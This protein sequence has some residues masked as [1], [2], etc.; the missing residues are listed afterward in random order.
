MKA[1]KT[2]GAL[3]LMSLIWGF[4]FTAVPA[5]YTHNIPMS[6]AAGTTIVQETI[7]IGQ[8]VPL[9][10]GEEGIIVAFKEGGRFLANVAGRGIL[11]LPF[12]AIA[13][14]FLHQRNKKLVSKMD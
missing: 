5:V 6:T 11:T 13:W 9:V 10:T 8:S 14:R 3:L 2:F 4:L 7:A 1:L 12:N